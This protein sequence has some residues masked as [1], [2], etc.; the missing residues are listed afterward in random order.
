[1]PLLLV[2]ALALGLDGAGVP[3]GG[4]GSPSIPVSGVIIPGFA[5]SRLRAWALLDCPYS[6]L[7]FRPL[8]PV[9]LDT[10]KVLSV[11]NCWL[12][13]M[14]LDPVTQADHPECKSRPDTGLSAITELDPGYITGA[15]SSV[16]REWVNWL[17]EFGIEP[18]AIV[19][20]PYDWRLPGAMLEERDL[21][22][23]KLKII[24]ET[25]RKLR[26]GPSLV[27]AHSM[28]NNVFRYF[29]EWLKLEIAPKHYMEWLDHHIHAYYA[30]GAPLLGSAETVKALMSGVTFGLP[31][32]DGTARVMC[33]SFASSLWMLPFSKHC[34][35]DHR[36]SSNF[37]ESDSVVVPH[38]VCDKKEYE[39]N[40]SSWPVNLVKIDLPA[41]PGSCP[42]TEVVA[43]PIAPL[44]QDVMSQTFQCSMPSQKSYTAHQVS[45]GTFLRDILDHDFN[46][47]NALHH[48]IKYYLEDP[49]LNPLTP[50]SRPPIKN[51][52]CIYG[53]DMKTEVG[54][55]FAPSG[56]AY[57]DNWIITDIIYETEGGQL[58]S[59]SGMEV[60]GSTG[61]SSGDVTVP[62]NSL[63]YCKTWL[64]SRVNITRTPQTAH[65]V[66]D[67]Q[68]QLN[69]EHDRESDI[70][71][72]MT[73]DSRVKYI[74]YYE[75]GISLSGKRTA[76]WELDKIDHRNIV[77]S[78]IL[79]RELW[80]E[81]AHSYHK[82]A[83][84]QF[85]SKERRE[86]M[87]DED[88]FWDYAKARCGRP[89]RCEYRYVFGD[90]HLGQSCRLQASSDKDHILRYI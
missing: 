10:K 51:V 88:C 27:Y 66:T 25:A 52:Y 29:L 11:L 69:V 81:T 55:H 47:P 9:W 43:H 48:L 56:K 22:F 21:Y 87:R 26:G 82:D 1:M 64:G 79:L 38:L 16:W 41:T 58:Q 63:S 33:N 73:R 8:D 14:L 68:E 78:S 53:V 32:S 77:R 7:D 28:G 83:K 44:A 37:R 6:P 46:S 84:R 61:P 59:R 39:R 65:E 50:W 85:V 72:N 70:V 17:V 5:S 40:S 12:K 36:M 62:Y 15:L 76:V 86:P 23:H 67:M 3:K 35:V 24:F 13:C 45:T 4:W 19:A 34:H 31:I 49:I 80:L 2:A 57:P 30:V 89:D 18:D 60:N 20:V 90:V 54:Y 42:A 75:D 74:T 71:P